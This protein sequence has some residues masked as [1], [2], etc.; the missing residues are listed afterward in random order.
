MRILITSLFLCSALWS[1][2]TIRLANYVNRWRPSTTC[3]ETTSGV[4]N[5]AGDKVA[6][7]IQVPTT[8]SIDSVDFLTGT[9][10]TADDL[11]VSLQDVSTSTG[12]PDG[13]NDQTAT[14]T[15]DAAD[16]GVW[17]TA[18]FNTA[19]SVTAGQYVAVVIGVDTYVDADLTI[20]LAHSAAG[21]AI[22]GYVDVSDGSA[23]TKQTAHGPLLALHYTTGYV[24]ADAFL[25]LGACAAASLSSSGVDQAGIVFRTSRA[26]SVIGVIFVGDVDGDFTVILYDGSNNVLASRSLVSSTRNSTG[27]GQVS[28]PFAA[29]SV[30]ASRDYR[31]VVRA[32]TAGFDTL[33]YTEVGSNAR[34]AAYPLGTTA[35]YTQRTGA[36]AWTDTNTRV[37]WMTPV[38]AA[39]PAGG[40][41]RSFA[42]H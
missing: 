15:L 39:L 5:G 20:S 24:A 38:I 23:W 32:D 19:R 2:S 25:P 30:E 36:G 40:G 9:V 29:T 17:K 4:I 35:Y 12:D 42:T 10:T 14:V 31:L 21:S 34:L 22:N 13:T 33:L 3:I 28:I 18:T 11:V 16:D 26:V 37:P 8:G 1:Q 6:F 7:V 27:I 41:T